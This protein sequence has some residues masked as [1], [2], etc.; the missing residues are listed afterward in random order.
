M[1]PLLHRPRA[2]SLPPY[3]DAAAAPLLEEIAAILAGRCKVVWQLWMSECGYWWDYTDMQSARIET[4]WQ[5]DY[6]RVEVGHDGREDCWTVNFVAMTQVRTNDS[7]N[8][9]N[10]R[11]VRRVYVT[12]R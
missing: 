11:P 4:A 12:H 9:G 3:F 1:P 5:A 10:P 8:T 6:T 7:N 2:R